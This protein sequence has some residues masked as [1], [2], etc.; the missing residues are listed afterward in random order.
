MHQKV[1]SPPAAP[2]IE[3][4][5]RHRHFRRSCDIA[6]RK[7]LPERQLPLCQQRG[8]TQCQTCDRWFASKGGLA[9][10]TC[11][12]QQGP[13]PDSTSAAERNHEHCSPSTTCCDH[14]CAVCNRFFRSS[15]G[16]KRHSCT[17]GARP[18]AADR[19]QFQHTWNI[20][21]KR[22]RRQQDLDRHKKFCQ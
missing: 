21:T 19:K 16:F 22:F 2:S 3:C 17:H 18:S 15:S 6:R 14:H 7:C 8:A 4:G 13:A 9:R 20:C 1:P 10:H 5:I 12:D 11:R